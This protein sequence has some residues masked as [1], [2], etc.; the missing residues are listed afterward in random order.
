MPDRPSR[1]ASRVVPFR[2]PDARRLKA[3]R[4]LSGGFLLLLGAAFLG[5]FSAVFFWSA[6]PQPQ[7]ASVTHS[8]RALTERSAQFPLC[9]DGPRITCVVDGDTIWLD[10]AKIRIAD[11]NT[12]EVS[13]PQCAAEARLARR[14]TIRLQTLLNQG[15]FALDAIDRDED[16]YGRKLRIITRGGTSLGEQL[17]AEG[18]AEPWRGRRSGWC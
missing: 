15:S 14:A 16:T 13:D 7:A 12:P 18:L 11:I 17:V 8:P 6:G 3:A 9:D 1:S 5:T 4:G 10:G 2:Q